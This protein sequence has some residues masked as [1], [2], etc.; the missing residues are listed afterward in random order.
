MT[1]DQ[2]RRAV[3]IIGR[4]ADRLARQAARYRQL[5]ASNDGERQLNE[6]GARTCEHDAEAL[7]EALKELSR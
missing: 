7:A 3:A 2:R 1:G 6:A 5:P 4:E